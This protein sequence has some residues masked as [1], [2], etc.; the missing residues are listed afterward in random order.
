MIRF[1]KAD[2]RRM[3][4]GAM[5]II[6]LIGFAVTLGLTVTLM[7]RAIRLGSARAAD[8][9]DIIIGAP[10]SPTQLVLST[11]F[12][13]PS[14]LPL[15]SGDVL[16]Q[17]K[18]DPRVEFA[19]PVGM[20]DTFL[21][22]PIIGVD[23]SILKSLF[24]DVESGSLM[25]KD[26]E[27]VIG[28]HV[29][30][31]IGKHIA[32]MH[33]S[34]SEGG[35]IHTDVRYKII[36]K[37]KPSGTAWDKAIF[38]P[39]ETVWNVHG[40][41]KQGDDNKPSV[42]DSANSQENQDKKDTKDNAEATYPSLDFKN[43]NNSQHDHRLS[44]S[45]LPGVPAVIVKPKSIADAYKIRQAYRNDQALAVFPGE[46]LTNLYGTLGDVR[47]LLS[48]IADGAQILVAAALIFVAITHIHDRRR[49]IGA[50]RAL[51]ASRS[52]ILTMVWLELMVLIMV[53][54]AVGYSGGFLV[55]HVIASH[56][57]QASGIPLPIELSDEDLGNLLRLIFT[58]AIISLVPAFMAWRQSPMT[59]LRS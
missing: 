54:I 26:G 18:N 11:V 5:A 52:V 7:E 42:A 8:Q 2:L 12:L 56:L 13:Q 46:I 45:G 49:Q 24:H 41:G 16:Q 30:I 36:G 25:P 15:M 44:A 20:G 57:G 10:G 28:A 39:I 38:V 53:G 43:Y 1:I 22:Y 21:D 27:A 6:I 3:W 29:D 35:H 4:L 23:E 34:L 32:P 17:L 33:G 37:L 19:S 59:A 58:A 48:L 55:S 31:A 51:G 9:F 47:K 14:A 40:L 50:L